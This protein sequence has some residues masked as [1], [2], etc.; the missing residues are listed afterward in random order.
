[1]L[2]VAFS[3]DHFNTANKFGVSEMAEI[4]DFIE[5][6]DDFLG[7]AT[8]AATVG[9]GNWKITDTSSAG[10]PTYT[11]DASSNGGAVTLAFDNTNEVQNICLD[12][13]DKLQFD[14]DSIIEAEFRVKV[15]TASFTAA[16]TL[17]FGLQS[18]R[19]DDT[20]AT[21][22][23]AQFKLA[24]SNSVVCESDDSATDND[25]KATGK[26]LSTTYKKF[27]ISFA[28]GKSDVRFYIDGER[29]ASSTT[30]TLA[31]MTT[32]FQPFV[33]LSKTASTNT[34]SVTIDYVRVK[35]RR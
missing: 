3:S 16:N 21:T 4:Q 19:N 11:K 30:F 23:N 18:G 24:G 35:C 17:A 20:D 7:G 34:D 27:L 22:Y 25:D 14:V 29:V 13:G 28:N 15:S 10:T 6:T 26:T 9:E 1:M 33:Q 12:F 2:L 32:S 31:T 5:F 8:I